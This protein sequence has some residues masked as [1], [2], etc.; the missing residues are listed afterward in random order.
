MNQK[1]YI[2]TVSMIIGLGVLGTQSSWAQ[3]SIGQG[4]GGMQGQGRGQNMID[5]NKNGIPDGQ[6]DAD[7]DGV[8]NRDDSDYA[9]TN[10]NMRDADS[11]GVSNHDDADYAPVQDGS[12]RLTNNAPQG[13]QAGAGQGQQGIHE[14]GTGLANPELKES[15]QGTGQGVNVEQKGF[16]Y[17]NPELES[18]VAA[19]QQ[20]QVV[21]QNLIQKNL[22]VAGERSELA[23]FFMG[24]DYKSLNEV[25]NRLVQHEE[26]IQQLRNIE[27]QTTDAAD[28]LLLNE[29]I[30]N[31]EQVSTQLK[32]ALADG[33][34]N[35]FS[36]FGWAFKLF[37]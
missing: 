25:Q 37:N 22:Q 21:A 10:A 33:N 17:K 13:A 12:G 32:T 19:M 3:G 26:K 20:E 28:K 34:N 11:D 5:V 31:M 14:P 6:E 23:K 9:K 16:R 15:R 8:L 35:V 30:K 36:L 29:Q 24:P 1:K 27:T 2:I 7:G 4:N 18:R